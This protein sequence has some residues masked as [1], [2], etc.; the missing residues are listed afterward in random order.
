MYAVLENNGNAEDLFSGFAQVLT[1]SCPFCKVLIRTFYQKLSLSPYRI[2][3][4]SL[5]I[6]YV[7]IISYSKY[8]QKYVLHFHIIELS[9]IRNCFNTSM[10]M[11][12]ST[13][14]FHLPIISADSVLLKSL[15]FRGK[16][17]YEPFL[18]RQSHYNC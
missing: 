5:K 3:T 1:L 15:L 16:N 2:F 6:S 8:L 13:N 9:Q 14:G 10:D 11:I 17:L 7:R 18:S 4:I 12:Q